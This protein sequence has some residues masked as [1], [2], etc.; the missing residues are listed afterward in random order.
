MKDEKV[1]VILMSL[2]H[3]TLGAIYCRD[4]ADVT[5][6]R[7]ER[8]RSKDMLSRENLM[9]RFTLYKACCLFCIFRVVL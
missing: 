2:I 3:H 9:L 5:V 8:W 6:E 1:G 4:S 7:Y